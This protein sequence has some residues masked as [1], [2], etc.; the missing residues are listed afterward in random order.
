M[1][2]SSALALSFLSILV[3]ACGGPVDERASPLPACM[4]DQDV[5]G[6]FNVRETVAQLHVWKV[7]PGTSVKAV[8]IGGGEERTG[9]AD[10]MGAFV[11][12]ELPAGD[13]WEVSATVGGR[14]EKRGPFKVWTE[15]ESLPDPS[16][17]TRQTLQPGY[18]YITT[19]D[20]TQL[21]IFVSLPGP[22]EDGP[23]PTIVNYSGYAPS[24]PG[25][26]IDHPLVT[27]VF[28]NTDTPP[29]PVLC[30]APNHPAGLIVGLM[31]YAT[32]GVNMRGTGCSGGAYDFFETM[33]LLDGYDVI[34]T[35][36]AQP[37]VK[38]NEVG[39]V[40]LSYPGLSQLWVAKTKPPSLAAI[41]PLSVIADA[42]D[43][44]LAPAGIYNEGFALRWAGEVLEDAEPFGK[45]GLMGSS[46]IAK[47][48]ESDPVCAENQALHAQQVDV[49]AKALAHPFYTPE[50]YDPMRPTT[51]VGGIDVP[52]FMSG[53][54]QDEQ[55]G[56]YFPSLFDKFSPDIVTKFTVM[57]GRH[58]DGYTPHV[59]T[60]LKTFLDFYVSREL[61]T[62]NDLWDMGGLLFEAY[63][64]VKLDLPPI[65]FKD[66]DDYG[67]ALAMYEGEP[68]GRIAFEVGAP[69]AP[70]NPEAVPGAPTPRF[71]VPFQDWPIEG[72]KPERW[73]FHDGGLLSATPPAADGTASSFLLDEGKA[74]EKMKDPWVGLDAD[75]A[76]VF[77][78]SAL[79]KDLAI[80]GP[81]SAD[82][83]IRSTANDADMEVV[84][85]EV[86]PD[87]QEVYVQSGW[88]RAS[89][90]ALR[91]DA[92]ELRPIKSRLEAD[93]APLVPG[94]WVEARVEIFPFAHVFRAGSQLRITVENPGRNRTDWSF[95]PIGLPPG[96]RHSVGH[97]ATHASSVLL[98]VVPDFAVPA[99]A[100]SITPCGA[101]RAQPCRPHVPFVNTAE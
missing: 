65:R 94:E 82:L 8:R 88:V 20:G 100:A 68:R 96:T 74:H 75:K 40:G 1:K 21:S 86:R 38:H 12:R 95:I 39:M 17:Y 25:E 59:L 26:P 85:L 14:E 9:T 31:G 2:R 69:D 16:C 13:D 98:P 83:W 81:A 62:E 42:D 36:A 58:A 101:L 64:G 60:E 80:V 71:N 27:A 29:Y 61:P 56:G 44:T 5:T 11:F 99:A 4:Q 76:V 45:G 43:S 57:N 87:G 72:T 37:W 46:W 7:D 48:S 41:A 35:V 30:D 52:V 66:I 23:Y 91:S 90:R 97:D 73:Y 3:A 19:R 78:S 6:V 54:W 92:T 22:I 10:T 18:G 89:Y 70:D 47:Q 32:V 50:I 84:V 79:A 49:V 67:T 51:F 53:Q 63:L 28:C 77:E 34:E 33:Q 93:Y 15:A 24:K 55:T